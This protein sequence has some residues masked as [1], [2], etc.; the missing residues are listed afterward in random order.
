LKDL[1]DFIYDNAQYFMFISNELEMDRVKQANQAKL[2]R[3]TASRMQQAR[4]QASMASRSKR[5]K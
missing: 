3:E 4:M 1:P 2:E 5:I